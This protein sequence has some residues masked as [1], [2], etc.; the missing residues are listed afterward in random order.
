MT[1]T[2]VD[3]NDDLERATDATVLTRA[4]TLGHQSSCRIGVSAST[5]VSAFVRFRQ[6]YSIRQEKKKCEQEI[7]D[8]NAPCGYASEYLPQRSTDR[9]A[10][11]R[12]NGVYM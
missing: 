8:V 10:R 9:V 4:T 2:L 3:Y 1:V 11:K 7:H 5:G 12:E 6:E